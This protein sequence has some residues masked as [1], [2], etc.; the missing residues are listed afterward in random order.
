MIDSGATVVNKKSGLAAAV[1]VIAAAKLLLHLAFN[2]RYGFFRD[3]LYLIVC[4]QRLDFGFVDH[5]PVTPALASLS[6]ALFG[7]SVWS[8]R[9][10]PALAGAATV[11]LAGMIA[12]SWAAAVPPRPWPPQP[13]WFRGSFSISGL[14]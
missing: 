5:P 3:E 12:R 10:F 8:L 4:G 9:L 6:R 7:E 11:L 1:P 2:G 14:C 13:S